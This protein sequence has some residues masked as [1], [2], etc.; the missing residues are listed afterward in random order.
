M[1]TIYAPCEDSDQTV[2][3][4]AADIR[5]KF[6][7]DLN[8]AK[9]TIFYVFA[10]SDSEESGHVL[11]HGGYPAAATVKINSLKDRVEGKA[12]STITIDKD[13]WDNHD[14]GE[15]AALIDHELFHLIPDRDKEGRVKHDDAGRPKLKMR[16]HDWQIGGFDIIAKRHELAAEEVKAIQAVQKQF[17]Q[18]ELNLGAWG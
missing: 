8:E 14:Q 15:C 13:W 9:V 5:E 17:V 12:D 11:K 7:R 10:A 4:I 6:H 2:A 1:P 16:K 18:M 3:E